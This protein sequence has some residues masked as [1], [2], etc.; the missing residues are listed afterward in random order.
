MIR[1]VIADDHPKFQAAVYNLLSRETDIEVIGQAINGKDAYQLTKDLQ[2]DIL[3]LDFEMPDMDGVEVAR[4]L[5]LEKV[6]T[7]IIILSAQADPVFIRSSLLIG[8]GGY[9]VKDQG[10]ETLFQL[11]RLLFQ[12]RSSGMQGV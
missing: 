3:V 5:L 7:S 12:K 1:I 4:R 9:V 10:A 11:I 6:E 8:I 2:P